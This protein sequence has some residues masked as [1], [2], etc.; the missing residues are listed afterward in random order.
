MLQF[1][2]ATDG[3]W[4]RFV[5]DP[6]ARGIGI[7]RYPLIEANDPKYAKKLAKRTITNV[8][9]EHSDW[10]ANA[11]AKLAAAYGFPVDLTDEQI[12]ERL[13]AFNQHR[14]ADQKPATK[15]QPRG[16][17]AKTGDEFV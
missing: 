14:F 13:L 2:G 11:H 8:Y 17:R 15:K 5:V 9:N 16:S 3:P 7:V 12:L 4:S 6:D 10:L 1:P